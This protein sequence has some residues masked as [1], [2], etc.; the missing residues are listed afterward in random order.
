MNSV[1]WNNGE[2][3]EVRILF[4]IQVQTL[5]AIVVGN[6]TQQM[7]EVLAAEEKNR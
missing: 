2:F 3:F 1:K 7:S 4:L 6:K 5:L